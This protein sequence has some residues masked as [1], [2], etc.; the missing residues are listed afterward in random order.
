M[1]K[2]KTKKPELK[3]RSGFTVIMKDNTPSRVTS[4]L[5]EEVLKNKY[6][7]NLEGTIQLVEKSGKK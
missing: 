2:H 6:V 4:K 5:M 1:E 3:K 7:K